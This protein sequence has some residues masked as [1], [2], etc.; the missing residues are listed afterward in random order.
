MKRIIPTLI[1]LLLIGLCS[2]AQ[3]NTESIDSIVR[4]AATEDLFEGT[5]L[6]A[7]KGQVIYQE[8][9]GFADKDKT[10]PIKN[11]THFGIASITKMLTALAILQ[12]VDEGKIQLTDNLKT[13]LPDLEI[14]KS[15]K[16]TV[17]HLLLHISGLPN[18]K[19]EIFA[20]PL[21]PQ[22]FINKTLENKSNRFGTF[23]YAN[24]D[25]VLLGLI[26][27][28][29]DGIPWK[30]AIQKRILTKA[31]M[32]QTGF[33]ERGNYPEDFAYTFSYGSGDVRKADPLFFIEDF[34]AAGCMYA[35]AADLLKLDQAMYGD[36]LISQ[37]S[38]EVMFTSYPEYNYS[39]YSVWTYNY[40]FA[41]SKPKVM[42]RRGG[43][44]GSNSVLIRMLETNKTII[45]LSNNDKFNPDSFGN[46]GGLKEALMIELD[47]NRHK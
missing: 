47:K 19:D 21:S 15:N 1:S 13:L 28:K 30:N 46:T 41:P 44:L 29:Q 14:P 26:I 35:T 18:E 16:I 9:F 22:E 24:I 32:Q 42:E 33:L 38:K 11:S 20:Q 10:I 27:E 3:I 45:I 2:Q 40:P 23:N 6:I 8:S 34:Y 7:E 37:A 36:A 31:S 39:G 17:H 12:L 25:Y 4:S 43:I 5:I